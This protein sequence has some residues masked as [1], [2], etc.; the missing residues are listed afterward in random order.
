MTKKYVQSVRQW[1]IWTTICQLKKDITIYEL[2]T[3]GVVF[4][5]TSSTKTEENYYNCKKHPLTVKI[6]HILTFFINQRKEQDHIVITLLNIH[7]D[8]KL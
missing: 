3:R 8:L 2:H 7:R 4:Q 6:M 1:Y 5:K